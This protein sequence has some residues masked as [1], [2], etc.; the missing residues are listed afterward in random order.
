MVVVMLRAYSERTH[1]RSLI[2]LVRVSSRILLASPHSLHTHP[3]STN[4]TT[5]LNRNTHPIQPNPSQ[6][7]I[8][9][10]NHST[11]NPYIPRRR[12]P[13]ALR[14]PASKPQ[15]LPPPPPPPPPPPRRHH[16][17][18][19]RLRTVGGVG[20]CVCPPVHPRHRYPDTADNDSDSNSNVMPRS[21]SSSSRKTIP[22]L[23]PSTSHRGKRGYLHHHHPPPTARTHPTPLPRYPP[24]SPS[25]SLQRYPN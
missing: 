4:Q 1:V 25:I 2:P 17:R 20:S 19:V 16:V 13:S 22:L 14:H 18:A 15:H 5:D 24:S 6:P 7:S 8:H 9:T 21:S 3:P 11:A 12:S 23:S 10:A